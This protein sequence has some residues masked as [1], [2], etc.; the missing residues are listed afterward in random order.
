MQLVRH[1]R[2]YFRT[3][4][5]GTIGLLYVGVRNAVSVLTGHDSLRGAAGAR[6]TTKSPQS[7][8]WSQ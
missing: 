8:T 3:I 2:W 7:R 1:E 6:V 4:A 5:T